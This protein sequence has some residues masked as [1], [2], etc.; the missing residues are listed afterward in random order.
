MTLNEFRAWLEGY[1]A[2]FKGGKPNAD[3]WSEV[4]RRLADVVPVEWRM[5]E[6]TIWGQPQN[7]T[8]LRGIP[9]APNGTDINVALELA[10]NGTGA[11][12][13]LDSIPRN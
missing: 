3:Q 9:M 12:C 2:S 5:D 8:V 6:R 4:Q 11:I 10:G 13:F 1:S 7:P